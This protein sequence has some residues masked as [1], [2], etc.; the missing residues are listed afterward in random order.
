MNIN[1][2]LLLLLVFTWKKN[3]MKVLVQWLETC[4]PVAT[5]AMHVTT[6]P[7]NPFAFV[8]IVWDQI[9]WNQ[10]RQ[11]KFPSFTHPRLSNKITFLLHPH[12][13]LTWSW[14][15]F[16]HLTTTLPISLPSSPF[17]F[18]FVHPLPPLLLEYSA[19]YIY[20]YI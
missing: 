2:L 15:N 8:Q 1:N 17:G 18:F 7:P 5:V 20:I 10:N 4:W 16:S 9:R 14:T 19:Y 11:I 13:M 6:D 3:K 12:V